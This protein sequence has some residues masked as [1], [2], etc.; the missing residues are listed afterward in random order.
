MAAW[1]ITA[2]QMLEWEL[3]GETEIFG[4][5]NRHSATLSTTNPTRPDTEVGQPQ[6]EAGDWTLITL[7]LFTSKSQF[8]F[9]INCYDNK[10]SS[11]TVH[12]KLIIIKTV[13][14]VH[15]KTK[16]KPVEHLTILSVTRVKT[17]TC[18]YT[19]KKE[20]KHCVD[21]IFKHVSRTALLFCSK[22]H[23]STQKILNRLI[24]HC[25]H[26]FHTKIYPVIPKNVTN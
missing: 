12:S 4:E 21:I 22:C 15:F 1:F 11:T 2:E 23:I 8:L 16:M 10:S 25:L 9:T 6:R 18:I 5:K 24:Q 3:V 17:M 26:R 14:S 20:T 13:T 7:R 19:T